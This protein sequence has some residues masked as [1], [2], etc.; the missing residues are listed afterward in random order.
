VTFVRALAAFALVFGGAS[1]GRSGGAVCE[2]FQ[3]QEVDE[4]GACLGPPVALAGLSVC[5]DSSAAQ[6]HS[7]NPVCLVGDGRLFRGWLSSTQWLEGA[8][9]GHSEVN[10]DPSTLAPADEARCAKG[11]PLDVPACP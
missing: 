3:A 11:L 1:C 9:W 10:G 5:H 2:Q 6:G 8:S 7:M 4:P